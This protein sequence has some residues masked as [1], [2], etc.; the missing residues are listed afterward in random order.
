MMEPLGM[1][2]VTAACRASEAAGMTSEAPAKTSK[3][4][5]RASETA[6]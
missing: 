3:V 4:A 1:M 2:N 5:G 6:R